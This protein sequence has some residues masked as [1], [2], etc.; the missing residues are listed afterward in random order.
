MIKKQNKVCNLY[1]SLQLHETYE[2]FKEYYEY[3]LT[4]EL[5]WSPN[6]SHL[7]DN[8]VRFFPLIYKD[9][10]LYIVFIYK[11]MLFFTLLLPKL[12]LNFLYEVLLLYPYSINTCPL[13][14]VYWRLLLSPV[15]TLLLMYN[16][17]LLV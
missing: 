11:I 14:Q 2:I 15:S 3:N 16:F 9:L 8:V 6:F 10:F 7:S 5:Y 17:I 12:S 4:L 1:V 13:F